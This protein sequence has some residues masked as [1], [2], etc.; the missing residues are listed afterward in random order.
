ML[1]GKDQLAGTDEFFGKRCFKPIGIRPPAGDHADRAS[2]KKGQPDGHNND[3]VN[4]LADQGSQNRPFQDH[5]EKTHQ[6]YGHQQGRPIGKIQ[7]SDERIADESPEHQKLALGEINN[8]RGLKDQH[9]AQG[10]QSINAADG[11]TGQ[12]GLCDLVDQ[13]H[14]VLKAPPLLSPPREDEGG[15]DTNNAGVYFKTLFLK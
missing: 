8:F 14:G 11:Y 9:K 2:Q 6:D 4:R 1:P 15:G 3:G 12:N 13:A 10:H 5:A 7:E